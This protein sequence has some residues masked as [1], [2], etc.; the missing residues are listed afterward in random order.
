MVVDKEKIEEDVVR[1]RQELQDLQAE[2]DFTLV[3]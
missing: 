1:L 3:G 2:F